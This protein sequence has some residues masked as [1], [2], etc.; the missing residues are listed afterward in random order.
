MEKNI[1]EEI[2]S[3]IIDGGGLSIRDVDGNQKPFS[4]S[5]GNRGPGYV[6]I[7]G[8]VGQP[9]LLQDL[10]KQLALKL[11]NDL[12]FDFIAGNATG[13]M[14]PGW[15]LRNDLEKLTGKEIPYVYVRETRKIA[16]HKEYITGDMNNP[17]ILEGMRALVFEELVNFAETICNSALVLRDKKYQANVAA[18]ILSY[19]NPNALKSLKETGVSLTH[20]IDLKSLIDVA[21]TT[22]KF[23]SRS[24][25][26]YREFLKDPTEWQ[27]KRGLPVSAKTAKIAIE[28]GYHMRELSNEEAL[29]LGV[30]ED[31]LKAGFVYWTKKEA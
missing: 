24:I 22:G 10:T 20:L 3:K 8:L 11:A 12:N 21:D 15:Q 18:T 16:G 30:P 6:M 29:K 1:L 7:K 17:L 27:I 25:E 2:G 13:G 4:Y 14:V 9:H 28:R 5:S 19:Q 31:Q 23:N 26:S